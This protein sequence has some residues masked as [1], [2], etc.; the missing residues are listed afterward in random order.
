MPDGEQRNSFIL[1]TTDRR[2]VY[3]IPGSGYAACPAPSPHTQLTTPPGQVSSPLV[4]SLP[5][6]RVLQSG[7]VCQTIGEAALRWRPIQAGTLSRRHFLSHV[8]TCSLSIAIEWGDSSALEPRSIPVEC[9]PAVSPACFRTSPHG[10]QP[11]CTQMTVLPMRLR[12]QNPYLGTAR[13]RQGLN[14]K[15]TPTSSY[16]SCDLGPPP[17]VDKAE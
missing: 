6:T 11:Q 13:G 7:R 5:F 14:G 2:F 10:L 17:L 9:L 4:T 15:S 8:A 12:A 1:S 3:H 16:Y